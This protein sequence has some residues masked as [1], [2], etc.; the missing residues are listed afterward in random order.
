MTLFKFITANENDGGLNPVRPS[1]LRGVATMNMLYRF[2][3]GISF[4]EDSHQKYGY[5]PVKRSGTLG[6]G[7]IVNEYSFSPQGGDNRV[8]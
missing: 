5:P 8:M 2:I 7:F 1:P 3:V 6:H 4:L